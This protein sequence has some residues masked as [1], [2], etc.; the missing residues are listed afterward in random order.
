MI[1]NIV[2]DMGMVLLDYVP[3]DSCL[4][5]AG[6]PQKAAALKEAIFGHPDWPRKIDS[7][8]LHADE[9][10]TEVQERLETQELKELAAAVLPTGGWMACIPRLACSRWWS[11]C[12]TEVSACMC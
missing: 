9:Y 2:F 10:L 5:H 8:L 6:D 1:R 3:Y 11:S 4:S 12:W 7:G